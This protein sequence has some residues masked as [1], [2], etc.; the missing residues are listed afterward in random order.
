MSALKSKKITLNSDSVE[1]LENLLIEIKKTGNHCKVDDNLLVSWIIT[2]Y[3]KSISKRKIEEIY[4]RFLDENLFSQ[5]LFKSNIPLIEANKQIK[6]MIRKR[7]NA[8][9]ERSKRPKKQVQKVQPQT[10]TSEQ[11]KV[12]FE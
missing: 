3:Q 6:E 7:K 9:K 10:S 11:R 12:G 2:D 5:S 8:L 1:R 4:Y